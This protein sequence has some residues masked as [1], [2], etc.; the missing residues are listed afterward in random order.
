MIAQRRPAF[1][2]LE[3]ALEI[4]PE[5]IRKHPKVVES[6]RRYSTSPD[7]MLL[8]KSIHYAAMGR[9]EKKWKRGRPDILHACLLVLSDSPLRAKDR[10]GI[11]FQSFDGRVFEISSVTRLPKTYERFKGVMASALARERIVDEE[12]RPLISKVADDLRQFLSMTGYEL[13]LLWERGEPIELEALAEI[14]TKDGLLLGI[15]CFPHGDFEEETIR[16]AKRGL[17]IL[18]GGSLTAWGTAF[19]VLASIERL[20]AL[21][22]ERGHAKV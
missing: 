8:D 11:Y 19:R 5:E 17:S 18:C 4:V 12:G 3:C 21:S 22:C 14:A 16:L 1:I 9:L 15:G 20:V 2:F 7:L 13:A 6:A 10:L